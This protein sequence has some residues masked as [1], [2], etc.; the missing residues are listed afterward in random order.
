MPSIWPPLSQFAPLNNNF[1][2]RRRHLNC[3]LFPPAADVYS[4]KLG[5]APSARLAALLKGVPR[6]GGSA[7]CASSHACCFSRSSMTR[8]AGGSKSRA[9]AVFEYL[10]KRGVRADR[11]ITV[12]FGETR[13]VDTNMTDAG[14]LANRRVEFMILDAAKPA[15]VPEP[16]PASPW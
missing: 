6:A 10:L 5:R 4:V 1:P 9:D 14:K 11:M 13:P 8:R 7:A 12:G 2:P 15:A 3:R 16:E